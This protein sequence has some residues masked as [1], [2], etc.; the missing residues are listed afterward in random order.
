MTTT[1]KQRPIPEVLTPAQA[2][3]ILAVPNVALHSGLRHRVELELMLRGG[4]RVSEVAHLRP[5]D[6]VLDERQVL[7]VRHS[8]RDGHRNVPLDPR[9]VPW[10]LRW[11][12]ARPAGGEFFLSHEYGGRLCDP[13]GGA[14]WHA[15]KISARDAALRYPEAG[16]YPTRIYPHLFRHTAATW[17]Y[18][19]TRDILLVGR[20][21]GHQDSSTTQIYIRVAEDDLRDAINSMATAAQG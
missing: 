3:A 12:L 11:S 10:L 19:A 18:K 9:A 1:R 21:L 13:S 7:H 17:L 16:P 8:K 15:V 4:L 20:M 2:D 5:E 6:V 14:I